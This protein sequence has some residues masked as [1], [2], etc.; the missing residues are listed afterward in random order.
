MTEGFAVSSGIHRAVDLAR[1]A[2]RG[3]SST[4]VDTEHLL[5]SLLQERKRKRNFVAWCLE[6]FDVTLGKVREQIEVMWEPDAAA[7][8]EIEFPF[9]PRLRSVAEQAQQEARQ[10]GDD[11]LGT[12]HLLL[13]LLEE[14][15]G[16]A[17]QVLSNL[18]VDRGQARQTVMR[19]LGV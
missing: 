8:E 4:Q 16:G 14:P 19:M 9:T 12:E 6:E 10:L 15:E 18:G 17:A 1:E 2:A 13:G 5:L 7:G 3:Y 11:Y